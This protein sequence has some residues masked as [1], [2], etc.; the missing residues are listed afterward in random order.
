MKTT[1]YRLCLTFSILLV[2]ASTMACK[3][4]PEQKNTATV[5]PVVDNANSVRPTEAIKSETTKPAATEATGG[6]LATPTETYKTACA[7]RRKKDIAGLKHVLSKD[8]LGFFKEMGEAEKKTLDESLSEMMNQ[9]MSPTDECRN[10]QINGETATLEYLND[11]G[12]WSQMDFIKE[13]SD[14]KMTFPKA[15]APM[16]RDMQKK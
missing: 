5:K 7:A 9:P 13:G 10:E 2:F 4:S 14:W 11:K 6:S 8:L 12:K 3:V 15:G 1:P 16:T